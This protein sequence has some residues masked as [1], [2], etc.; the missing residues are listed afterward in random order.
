MSELEKMWNNLKGKKQF[1]ADLEPVA[2]ESDREEQY[3]SPFFYKD[4]KWPKQG[5][6]VL[7]DNVIFDH[8]HQSSRIGEALLDDEEVADLMAICGY[9][10]ERENLENGEYL[11]E[12]GYEPEDI[13]ELIETAYKHDVDVY[14]VGG[15][16]EELV[17]KG[18]S[19]EK[20]EEYMNELKK[21]AKP[22]NIELTEDGKADP[23][24]AAQ[25]VEKDLNIV[26]ADNDFLLGYDQEMPPQF[27][28][29]AYT[30]DTMANILQS[31]IKK[32]QNQQSYLQK[33]KKAISQLRS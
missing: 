18:A 33:A 17:E 22:L 10:P 9:L 5:G 29:H 8:Y 4:V 32:R 28:N 19:Q 13:E 20:V 12:G 3:V 7:D 24:I 6:F 21:V 11:F 2:E 30:V 16:G 14:Y 15:V 26:T 25:S 1:P 27:R 31:D 23:A